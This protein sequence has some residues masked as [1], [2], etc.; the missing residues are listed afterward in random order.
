[1]QAG[2][3]SNT[4][5]AGGQGLENVIVGKELMERLM[6]CVPRMVAMGLALIL[7]PGLSI[8]RE[9]PPTI[10]AIFSEAQ[11]IQYILDIEAAMARAQAAHGYIPQAAADEI[12]AKAD[13]KFAT[14]EDVAKEDAIVRHGMVAILNVWRRSV[15]P[16]AASYIHFGATTVDVYDTT[17]ALQLRASSRRFLSAMRDIETV[18][19]KMADDHK[20]TAMAGRTLGQHALPITFGKKVST[21]VGENRRNIERL[22]FVLAQLDRSAILKGAVGTY[23]GL[24]AKAI[25]VE[26]DFAKELGFAPPY[27]DDWHGTRDVFAD[28]AVTLALISKSMGRIGQEL[29]LLQSTDIGETI[30]TRKDTAV[31]SSSM[32]HKSNPRKSEK[33]MQ[34]AR[35]IPRLAE[36]ILDDVINFFERDNVSGTR[37]VLEELSVETEDMLKTANQ[38]LS[39]LQVEAGAMR[40]NLGKTGDLMMAQ[41]I[42]LALTD[43]IGKDKADELLRKLVKTAFEA[44]TSFR[45]GLI[46]DPIVSKHLSQA[47]IDELLDPLGYLGLSAEMVDAVSEQARAQRKTDPEP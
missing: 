13:V 27:A 11:R 16:V 38:L 40:A 29:F 43:K 5:N 39:T 24:G 35:L 41:R 45:A 10:T 46:A 9:P 22:K 3:T 18:L 28:Y 25:E 32:P 21:W 36:V 8:A 14:P 47:R 23:A 33:L 42:G 17:I 26:R 37:G 12:T 2:N 6:A 19:I 4:G 15:D 1:M 7:F 44:N 30:E 31:S 20:A 34:S